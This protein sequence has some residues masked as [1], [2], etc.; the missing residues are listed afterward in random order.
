[1]IRL[2]TVRGT[3]IA[4]VYWLTITVACPAKSADKVESPPDFGQ[5][6]DFIQAE[7]EK[8]NA[9]SLAAGVVTKD[10]TLWSAA[11]GL[12]K[13]ETNRKA[14]PDTI[15]RLASVSKPITATALMILVDQGLIDLDAPA[16]RY[17]P[18]AKL[19]ARAGSA[20]DMTVRRLANHT[21][22]LPTYYNFFYDDV[23]PTPIEESIRRYGFAAWTP[24]THW[25]Y[26]NLGFGILNAITEVVSKTPWR[27]FMEANVYD[28]IGMNRTS[29]RVRPGLEGDA[30][31]PYTRDVADQFV[32]VAPYEF[33]HPGASA[34]WSSVN[35]LGRFLRMHLN[36]GALDGVRVLSDASTR[37]MQVRTGQR[38]NAS[39]TGIGWAVGKMRDHRAI[40]HSGGMPGV[41]TL[42]RFFPDDGLGLV[43]LSNGEGPFAL[44]VAN[45][46]TQVLIPS[47]PD[48]AKAKA[49]PK[50]E[51]RST[52]SESKPDW[53]GTW[54]GTLIRHEGNIPLRMEIEKDFKTRVRFGKA[55]PMPL[56]EASMRDGRLNGF[57]VGQLASRPGFHGDSIIRF[58]LDRDGDHLTGVASAQGGGYFSLPHW[59]ELTKE[60]KPD[61]APLAMLPANVFVPLIDSDDQIV[62]LP[63]TCDNWFSN[64]GREADGN[65]G[66]APQLKLKGHQEMSV[67]DFDPAPMRG[68]IVRSATLHLHRSGPERLYRLTTSGIGADWVEGT[69]RGYAEQPG[70]STHNH[71][72]HPNIP[73]SFPGSDLCSVILGQGG[74]AWRMADASPPDDQGWQTVAV[75]PLVMACR[76]A[77][78]SHGLFLFDDTGSEWTRQG[79][80][81]AIR[82][83]PN[84]YVHSRESGDK[85]APYLTV[86]LGPEDD[87][88][89][90]SPGE[91][92]S[93]VA[94]L[95]A[96]EALISWTCPADTGPAGTIGFLAS[97]NDKA[98]PRYLIPLATETGQRVQMHLRDLKLP[99]GAK[100]AFKVQAVDGAGNIGPAATHQVAVSARVA[101]ALPAVTIKP[102]QERGPLPRLGDLEVAVID[103]LDKVQPVTG[104][105]IPPQPDGY[106]A[107]NH[108]WDAKQKH[109]RL[110]AGRNEFVGFQILLRG[111]NPDVQPSL[112]FEADAPPIAVEFGRYRAVASKN[113]PLP[114]PITPLNQPEPPI[115]SRTSASVHAD[116]YVPHNARSG[117]HRGRLT[118]R[119]G[120]Q[121][122]TLP[123]TLQVW[124]FT[125]PD[126]LSFLPEMNC[127]SLPSNEREFY[128]LAHRHRTVVNRVP[129][130]QSGR[131]DDG[132]APVWD[133]KTLDWSAWDRRFGPYFDG[134]A[135]ADLP[136]QRVPIDCFYLPMHEN[137]PTPMEGNY[138]GDYWAD[139][140][141]PPGYRANFV[142]VSRQMSRHI[143]E[144]K[145]NDTLFQGFLNNKNNFKAN[146]WSR[147]SSP[148]LL[149]EPASFQDFWALRYFGSAFHEGINQAPGQAKLVFRADI[150]RP[151]WQRDSLD[152]LLDYNVV[153]SAFR[154]YHRMVIDRKSANGELVLEYGGSNAIE[155]ANVQ[156]VGWC[157]DTWA[158]GGDGVIP[159]Q[160][161]GRAES[162]SRA[163]EL[164]LFYPGLSKGAAPVP[165]IRLKAYRRGQ[166]DVEYLTLLATLKNQ[167]RWAVGGRVR[168]ALRLAAERQATGFTGGED[169]GRLHYD[170]LLPQDLWSLR[171]RVGQAL[172]EAH[173]EP[174]RQVIELRTP[175]R[176]LSKLAPGYVSNHEPAPRAPDA[177]PAAKPGVVKVLQGRSSVRDALI[178][179]G[180]ADR[181]LGLARRDNAVHKA[182]TSSSFLVRFDLDALKLPQGAKITRAALNF[183]VWDPS[184]QAPTR[185]RALGLNTPWTEAAATWRQAAPGQPWKGKTAFTVG[186]DTDPD[187]PSVV[188]RPDQGGDVADPP[189]NYEIDITPLVRAWLDGKRP[190]LGLAIAPVSDRSIDE[191]HST[192]FQIYASEY[193]K[194]GFTPK[195][196]VKV[197]P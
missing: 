80:S 26:S 81:F 100:V 128:R 68:R 21:S 104:A 1:M 180:Q 8:G 182:D 57:V 156:A 178:D 137:W 77:G 192:R 7:I 162:W 179:P 74:T 105:M 157:L 33:D 62:K 15:Y 138:N 14:T 83:T 39:G 25:N 92:R 23:S 72:Q 125:L 164:A 115:P 129:Y 197:Q 108:L 63:I 187:G 133:G 43:V 5:V 84:R 6:A 85:T 47:K 38:S 55:S 59:V 4:F 58:G 61:Q 130:S 22:G 64:V 160:T 153:G 134:S 121:S 195:L 42:V 70:S 44:N 184:S 116:V 29:D 181:A 41:S 32:A 131:I 163:D 48:D 165:S 142:E 123:V 97:I 2:S 60:P 145:W 31:T 88:P 183:S 95:P 173:P 191:G 66:G 113:G 120:D 127:Y 94:D 106:L 169:A 16:N 56:R 89:P 101:E 46:L 27:T 86:T 49:S 90:A 136:R 193:P 185:V 98:V 82:L 167:P 67:L 166:Q 40:E 186:V 146:G 53:S 111:A 13:I 69:G 194:V 168:E 50:D 190:N 28:P 103:E 144:K 132:C 9:P 65:N 114:D 174:K 52:P 135:F 149:D 151:E 87:D 12:A 36:G 35:D 79:E 161:I 51:P 196:T 93:E 158:L 75:D 18:G 19:Q 143:N 159:W 118:L 155:A 177:T 126:Y 76:V 91:I 45:R 102:F 78:L 73:W 189:V 99:A 11:F 109:I 110:H 34:V 122:L 119:N 112:R 172:S 3:A 171:L 54:N 148:W 10:G 17:L 24:G 20:D 117:E 154:P 170:R 96:G 71:R 124:D 176:D 139:R 140:A 30:A 37:A 152:G 107:A 175:R 188:V 141:F 150:S 147:G